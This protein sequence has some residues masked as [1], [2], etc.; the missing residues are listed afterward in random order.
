MLWPLF[1][2]LLAKQVGTPGRHRRVHRRPSQL[3]QSGAK[4]DIK[5]AAYSPLMKH[6][7]YGGND[8]K[9]LSEAIASFR[10]STSS[11]GEGIR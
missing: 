5:R 10:K 9:M 7:G 6:C 3:V 8:S 11:E 2:F 4:S 1:E